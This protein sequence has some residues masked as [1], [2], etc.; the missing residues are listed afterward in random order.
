MGKALVWLGNK[1]IA[2]GLW[3]KRTWNKFLSKLMFKKV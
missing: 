2:L 3:C 1:I